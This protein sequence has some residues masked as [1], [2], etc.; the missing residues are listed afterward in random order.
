MKKLKEPI[1]LRGHYISIFGYYCWSSS[2][3][4]L[5]RASLNFPNKD[6][7]IRLTKTFKNKSL[8]GKKYNEEVAQRMQLIYLEIINNPN[9]KI[10]II[11]GLDSICSVCSVMDRNCFLHIYDDPFSL[12][13]Y[14]LKLNKIY[15]SKTIINRIREYPGKTDYQFLTP[16]FKYHGFP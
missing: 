13:E 9:K 4:S 5:Y 12:E 15:K 10:K 7:K 14:G 3:E 6:A 1:K 2:R 16:T 8:K 11:K